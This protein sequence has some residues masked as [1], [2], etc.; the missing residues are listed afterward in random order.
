MKTTANAL[1]VTIGLD[2]AKNFFQVHEIDATGQVVLRRKLSRGDVLRFFEAQPKAL[3]GIEACGTGHYWAR[4][5]T[6]L[7]HEVKL[8]PPTY[9]KAYVKR[10]KTDAADAE[11]ICEA[12]T[13][14][15]M[16]FVPIKSPEQQAAL[17]MHRS[18]EL[19][20]GQRTALVN[21]LRGHLAEL[22]IVTAKGIHRVADLVAELVGAGNTKIPPLA[23]ASLC[24]L[25][26]EI[27][28]VEMQIEELEAL[29]I[30]WHKSN[31]ASRRLA[32][33]PGVG[34]ITASAVVATIGDASNFTS[35]RHLSA[36]LGLTPRQNSSG[37]KARQGSISKAGNT[38]LRRLLFIGAI[39]VIRSK[40]AQEASSWL[41][42]LLER[43]PLKV[44]AIAL[45]NKTVR[46]IWA[47]L[48][49]GEAY[50]AGKAAPL[51]VMPA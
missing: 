5:I 37:G 46:V 12:V 21:A 42:R 33:I 35:P 31:E 24:C 7:G 10:G 51:S 16:H 17:M 28:A 18:R 48:Q 3:V 1:V 4:E 43:R 44:V 27:E 30:E 45:A 29:I 20:V 14:P 15:T 19:L 39:A 9:V 8:L 36:A 49:G 50:R 25:A 13:R 26:A 6:A 11:A 32:K 22:G 40:R 23:R 34:P 2:I 41:A 47:M 38:Y